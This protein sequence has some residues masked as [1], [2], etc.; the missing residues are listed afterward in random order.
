MTNTQLAVLTLELF[1]S[2]LFL[3]FDGVS[4]VVKFRSCL[5]PVCLR[6][7]FPLLPL[8]FPTLLGH[9]LCP[10]AGQLATSANRR[11][12]LFVP[13][14]SPAVSDLSVSNIVLWSRMTRR[15]RLECSLRSVT[16]ASS[17]SA[18]NLSLTTVRK[19][20]SANRISCQFFYLRWDLAS[21]PT[22]NI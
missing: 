8:F 2:E 6:F 19:V 1:T 22:V 7:V 5:S 13:F 11:L 16:C 20:S 17:R 21:L 9:L 18:T 3:S 10:A 12:L 15:S 4:I 14:R